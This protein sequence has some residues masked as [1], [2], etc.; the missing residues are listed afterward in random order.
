[1]RRGVLLLITWLLLL[2]LVY[3]IDSH[4]SLGWK[5]S[6]GM[7]AVLGL[8]MTV[9][10]YVKGNES[11]PRIEI[12]RVRTEHSEAPLSKILVTDLVN[13]GD[14]PDILTSFNIETLER[15]GMKASIMA[16]PSVITFGPQEPVC[17]LPYE[18]PVRKIVRCNCWITG[19][20]MTSLVN[21]L[22]SSNE[23]WTIRARARFRDSRDVVIQWKGGKWTARR[24]LPKLLGWFPV[25]GKKVGASS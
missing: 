11:G 18:I 10:S 2:A 20:G 3:A 15:G 7:V 4:T 17:D 1:M 21:A 9:V 5:E 25:R 16:A 14:T 12:T 23:S 22:E 13:Y 8:A 24:A 19:G 6:A